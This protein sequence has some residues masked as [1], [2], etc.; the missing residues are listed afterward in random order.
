MSA[1]AKKD[2]I[3]R[4]RQKT[5]LMPGV[6]GQN[7]QTGCSQDVHKQFQLQAVFRVLQ[8]ASSEGAAECV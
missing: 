2:N 7:R 8:Q 4:G 5:A 6:R 1:Y 3:S